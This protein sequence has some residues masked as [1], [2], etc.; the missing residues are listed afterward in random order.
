MIYAGMRGK[1]SDG[2]HGERDVVCMRLLTV[3]RLLAVFLTLGFA[4]VVHSQAALSRETY[5]A[6]VARI[7]TNLPDGATYRTDLEAELRQAANAYRGSKGLKPLA[8][9]D[10]K[11]VAAARAHAADMMQNDFVGH[12]S[13]SGA[14]FESRMRAINPGVMMLPRMAE[15]AARERSKG[16][17]DSAKA[18]RLFQQWVKSSAH[19]KTLRSRDYIAVATGVV[20]KDGK[21]FAVQIFSG[22][23][24]KTNM[25]G[26]SGGSP[27]TQPATSGGES[28]Y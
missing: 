14:G 10:E 5:A 9:A 20:E 2:T 22:P 3:Y 15:N 18:Q 6:Y 11:L 13:S 7:N 8:A 12:T 28:L 24:L 17:P 26:S 19:A 4:A 23:A 16:P 25:F 1:S 27:A 21:L